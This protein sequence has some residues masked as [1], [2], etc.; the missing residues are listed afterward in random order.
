[1]PQPEVGRTPTPT[2]AVGALCLLLQAAVPTSRDV[3][4]SPD[5]GAI[6]GRVTEQ[7][8]GRPIARA[9]VVLIG[10]SG[11]RHE[12]E[13]DPD[14]RYEFTG[15]PP[16]RYA[17]AASPGELRATHL[18][19]LLGDPEPRAS[20]PAR[21][22]PA[23]TLAPGEVR[24]GADIALT[25][26]LA[27]EGR[28][29]DENGEPM[30]GV[31]IAVLREGL[32]HP[33]DGI[34]SDDR[35]EYRAFGLPPGRYRVCAFADGSGSLG[36]LP[37]SDSR[38]VRTCHPS[39]TSETTAA[40]VAVVDMD[41]ASIDIRMQRSGTYSLSG[42]VV[43]ASGAPATRARVGAVGVGHRGGGDTGVHTD[44]GRFDIDGLIPGSYML[45]AS[46]GGPET[47]DDRRPPAREHE[48]AFVPVEIGHA[49]VDGL[50]IT[51]SKG[52]K[53]AGRVRFEGGQRP[54]FTRRGISVFLGSPRDLPGFGG[55][56]VMTDVEDDLT[57]VL[58][59]FF[60]LPRF[61]G[62]SGLPDGWVVASVRHGDRDITGQ[63]VEFSANPGSRPIEISVTNR[64]ARPSAR[65]LDQ[66]QPS[67][68]H[69][70]VVFPV[71]PARWRTAN[72]FPEAPIS[73]EGVMPLGTLLPGEYFVAA[74]SPQDRH[75]LFLEPERL[76]DLARVADR[77]TFGEGD[78]QT[79]DVR[80]R[81]L[82]RR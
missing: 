78:R 5:L 12:I 57:F 51:L 9:A 50:T 81:K 68:E 80:V 60:Q 47:P 6:S 75:L 76:E 39:A 73:T 45:I 3:T 74:L 70:A 58:E 59:G 55:L 67:T 29:L 31:E 48:M 65:I 66:G 35:G 20:L 36:P 64:A 23:V 16:G 42:V 41:I 40:D 79:L 2:L 19:Q 15:L 1:M 11:E 56:P 49:D 61:V 25:R 28:V 62:L 38:F 43:D 13:T 54:P 26:A 71:D 30:S 34:L 14:G 21:P 37:A 7:G 18:L 44:E 33:S 17:V 77:V 72:L 32:P 10:G 46:L 82:P 8:S 63:V 53:I 24:T 27:I 52:E 69:H 22:R 4:P